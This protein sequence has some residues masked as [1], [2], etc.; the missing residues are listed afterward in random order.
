MKNKLLFTLFTVFVMPLQVQ[1]GLS[2]SEIDFGTLEAG[3]K[4]SKSVTYKNT[5]KVTTRLIVDPT[6]KSKFC[7]VSAPKSQ[8]APGNQVKLSI[9]CHFKV[10]GY[11]AAETARIM[12]QNSKGQE[13]AALRMKAKTIANRCPDVDLNNSAPLKNM[14]ILDQDGTGMCYAF[15]GT[16]VVEYELKS[17]GINRSLSPID[18]GLVFK[19]KTHLFS[20]DLSGGPLDLTVND[21]RFHGVATRECVDKIIKGVA[22]DTT[23]TSETFTALMHGLHDFRKAKDQKEKQIAQDDILEI[24][25]QYGVNQKELNKL[26]ADMESTVKSYFKDLLEPCK[27]ERL[28]A[29][30][31][32]L[33]DYDHMYLGSDER[34]R[35]K[36][37][38]VLIRKHPVNVGICAEILKKE[39]FKHVGIEKTLGYRGVKTVV[40]NETTTTT[41]TVT[42][43]KKTYTTKVTTTKRVPDD[44]CAPHAVVITA[45][46]KEKGVCQYLIRNSWG[47]SW[48]G[49]GMVCACRT[50][51][52]YYQ[53]CSKAPKT[54]TNK[55]MVGC[56]VPEKTLLPNLTDAG[57]FED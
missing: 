54:E 11:N 33:P 27:K 34:L 28:D 52:N 55:V 17:K 37:N 23:L 42:V 8:V 20:K 45:Q 21:L 56:W 1:A 6:L 30:K 46:K 44:K 26:N 35:G 9:S 24:C 47:A 7:S 53:D 5:T 48:Q 10:A 13:V 14:P 43:G 4:I 22:K 38:D 57:G 12:I 41:T 51:K 31:W 32:K 49:N 39:N 29:L 18:A 50:A 19:T 3:T 16:T 36:V 40:E 2:T 15:T 25:K